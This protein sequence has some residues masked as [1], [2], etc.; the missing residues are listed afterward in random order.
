[1]AEGLIFRIKRRT[2]EVAARFERSFVR[3]LHFESGVLSL[4]F[5]D[6]P[7]SAVTTGAAI[8]EAEGVCGTYYL[9]GC[10]A[11]G[12][13]D[14]G[15]S[16]ASADI[17][18]LQERGHEIGCH[19][20][21]HVRTPDFGSGVI[22]RDLDKNQEALGLKPTSH[23][24]PYG[25]VSPRTKALLGKRFSTVRGIVPGLNVGAV[26]VAQLKAVPLEARSRNHEGLAQRI[27]D[28][29]QQ[30]GWLILFS[31]DVADDPSPYGCTPG[32]LIFAIQTAKK[33]GLKVLPVS[34][35]ARLAGA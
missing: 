26:D 21:A 28:A 11:D 24:F 10:F 33:A 34:E 1:M 2:R 17:R 31:H 25:E 16:Y 12:I 30:K 5:D 3:P 13:V 22:A 15:P 20:Y 19:S 23:A 27:A 4:T 7:R 8:L 29:A 9:A 14:G 35:A 6:A 18:A 32:D